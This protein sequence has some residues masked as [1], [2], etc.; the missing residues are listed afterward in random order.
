MNQAS[1]EDIL[2]PN[3]GYLSETLY[4]IDCV[5]KG[6]LIISW[7]QIEIPIKM[8]V[9]LLI[10]VCLEDN[11]DDLIKNSHSLTPVMMVAN[12]IDN[13]LVEV[14]SDVNLKL[15]KFQSLAATV[16]DFA[17]RMVKP[18][19]PNFAGTSMGDRFRSGA[20]VLV[21]GLP[22]T[23]TRSLHTCHPE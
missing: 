13:Y 8:E 14:A 5:F 10:R 11:D 4:E 17:S 19:N 21:Y 6:Y 1:I 18:C 15:E 2:I 12:L 16:P 22:K 9:K 23:V 3:M 7:L 20:T